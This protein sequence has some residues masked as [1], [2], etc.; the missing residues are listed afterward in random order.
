L[1]ITKKRLPQSHW[2]IKNWLGGKMNF[3]TRIS[4]LKP[5]ANKSQLALGIV[6]ILLFSTLGGVLFQNQNQTTTVLVVSEDSAAGVPVSEIKFELLDMNGQVPSQVLT[7]L[8]RDGF[9]TRSFRAGE[10]IQQSDVAIT[11]ITSSLISTLVAPEVIPAFTRTG[12]VV[13]LWSGIAGESA[14]QIGEAELID[15]RSTENSENLIVT[16]RVPLAL[17]QA[18]IETGADLR[19]VSAG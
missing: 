8:P 13:D 12:D 15:M 4:S 19:V 6:L 5:T 14:I 16:F 18:V 11:Q 10:I 17:V 3:Q 9:L 2:S 1:G 7:E